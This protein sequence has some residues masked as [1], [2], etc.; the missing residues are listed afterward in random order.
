MNEVQIGSVTHYFNRISVA[1]LELDD[2][3]EIGDVVHIVG[4]I[5]DFVMRVASMEIDHQKVQTVSPGQDVALQ[6]DEYVRAG[7]AI[8]KVL[9]E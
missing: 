8:F 4:R 5:T 1:V 2:E 6:V 3:L 7:D 9:A